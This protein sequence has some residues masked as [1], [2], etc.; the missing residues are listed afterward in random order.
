MIMCR[1]STAGR[2][3]RHPDKGWMHSE[4]LAL[5]RDPPP[6]LLARRQPTVPGRAGARPTQ[7]VAGRVGSRMPLVSS[8]RSQP[9]PGRP[10]ALFS[11]C[12]R[13]RR[14]T[15]RN[16]SSTSLPR[17]F[18]VSHTAAAAAPPAGHSHRVRHHSTS[19]AGSQLQRRSDAAALG[20]VGNPAA[21]TGAPAADFAAQRPYWDAPIPF[22]VEAELAATAQRRDNSPGHPWQWRPCDAG[23]SRGD[24][25]AGH[26]LV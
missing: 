11:H 9:S 10:R 7:Q 1:P 20:P 6:D 14:S 26:R 2:S 18:S 17:P 16:A 8:R 19:A 15:A 12:L 21:E 3:A 23:L 24:A 13:V 5:R 22:A 4:R 25:Q